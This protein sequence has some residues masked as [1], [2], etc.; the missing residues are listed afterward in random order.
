MCIALSMYSRIPVP[1]FPWQDSDMAYAVCFFPL[2]GAVTGGCCAAWLYVSMKYGAG[3]MLRT[4]VLACIPLIVTGGIHFDGFLDTSD[5]LASYQ[6]QEKRLEILKDPH[7]GAFA[8]IRALVFCGIY[9]GFVSRI[10]LQI[11][12]WKAAAV[13]CSG[14]V[15]S[16]I[17]SGLSVVLFPAAKRTGSLYRFAASADRVRSAAVLMAEGIACMSIMILLSPIPGACMAAAALCS[18]WYYHHT[19]VSGFGGITGDIAGWFVC[20]CELAMTVAAG[21]YAWIF[22]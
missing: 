3:D 18:F 9:T 10:S 16:R 13:W 17:L 7:V 20:I 12:P 6:T 14:F 21:A 8:V 15:L 1:S 11:L 5:A 22:C 4:A 19:A 2:V